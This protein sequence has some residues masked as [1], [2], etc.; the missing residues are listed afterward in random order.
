M[1]KTSPAGGGVPA[2]GGGGGSPQTGTPEPANVFTATMGSGAALDYGSCI[3]FESQC[4]GLCSYGIYSMDCVTGG[5]CLCYSSGV[6]PAGFKLLTSDIDIL[7]EGLEHIQPEKLCILLSSAMSSHLK[8]RVLA[9]L[10]NRLRHNSHADIEVVDYSLPDQP[11]PVDIIASASL[12]VASADDIASVSLAAS[13]QRPVYIAGEERTT[14][15]LRNYYQVLDASNLV[16]RF[17]PKGSRYSHMVMSDI[18]GSIDEY[19]ALRDHE[20]W[21]MYNSQQD[22][23][24]ISDFIQQRIK[25][26]NE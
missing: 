8:S 22:L 15:I 17:Y 13:L 5:I 1:S 6:E 19:S 11:S 26:L 18:S 3:T 25:I 16:R 23:D 12:V 9:L 2:L 20:P 14:G 4:N 24:N 10:V 21:A 7:A